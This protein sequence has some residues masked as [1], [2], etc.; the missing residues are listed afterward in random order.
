LPM[1]YIPS[2]ARLQHSTELLMISLRLRMF[3]VLP[4]QYIDSI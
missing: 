2:F 4:Q 3:T 1:M